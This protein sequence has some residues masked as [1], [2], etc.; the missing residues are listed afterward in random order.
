MKECKNCIWYKKANV[1]VF[2]RYGNILDLHH[3]KEQLSCKRD[4]P[5]AVINNCLETKSYYKRKWYKLFR[6]K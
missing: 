5:I 2:L 1:K 4:M 3:S 6:T